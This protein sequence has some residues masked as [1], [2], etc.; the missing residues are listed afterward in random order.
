MTKI[1]IDAAMSL[2]G[3]WADPDGQSV[4]PIGDMH[5]SGLVAPLAERTGAAIMSRRSFEM[6]E[7]PDWYAD[8]YELQVPI[9]VVTDRPAAKPPRENGRISFSFVPCFDAALAGARA[10]RKGR[11]VLII[12]ETGAVSAALEAQAVDELYLRIVPRLLG[13]GIPLFSG[14][15]PPQQFRLIGTAN[16]DGAVHLHF[17]RQS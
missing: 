4:Y 6:A 17:G 2:D 3:F 9:F 13:A 11:D 12:G 10:A 1:I 14:N 8:N 7:D 16:T 5:E 15:Q